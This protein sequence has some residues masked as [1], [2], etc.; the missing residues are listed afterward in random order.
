MATYKGIKG[1]KVQSKASDPTA[2]EAG[3]TVWYNT[4]TSALKY[5]IAGAGT[6]AA[7]GALNT[8][9]GQFGLTGTVTAAIAFGGAPAQ[10]TN[11][12]TYDGTSWTNAPTINTG[13][14]YNVGF[15]S[16]TAAVNTGG[17][18][19]GGADTGITET[20]NGS[21][22]S[23]SPGTLGQASQ[24]RSASNQAPSTTGIVFAGYKQSPN[25]SIDLTEQWNG[26]AWT[27]LNDLNTAREAGGGGG[28]QTAAFLASGNV[29]PN[30]Q[31]TAVE[32]WDGTSWTEVNN[33]NTGRQGTGSS[34]IT[35]SALLYGGATPPNS[36]LAEQYDGT[37]W[38]EVA[39]LA[40]ARQGVGKGTGASGGSALAAG[41]DGSPSTIT[42]EW[43][44]PVYTIKTV[45]IS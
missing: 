41:F 31:P 7:G 3:G 27:E 11:T 5:S 39:D 21:A 44:S 16:T 45:T 8:G 10:K 32:I 15:G 38:T 20:W 26:S 4:A 25:T 17:V 6:W 18:V 13:V 12:E 43:T 36:A 14:Q 34:G 30:T 37:S 9:R 42:E 1:V 2:S 29:Y 33:V 35:T 23:T 40:T 24:K 22:W 28:T 19:V